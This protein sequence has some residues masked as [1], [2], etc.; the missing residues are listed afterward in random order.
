MTSSSEPMGVS[1]RGRS[2]WEILE[3]ADRDQRIIGIGTL[4]LYVG[5]LGE[6]PR[7]LP[8]AT[9]PANARRTAGYHLNEFRADAQPTAR[10]KLAILS[11]AT[12]K[13]F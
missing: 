4:R 10:S 9:E 3:K 1:F 13:F 11:V 8:V 2:E 6:L 5:A 12:R 7:E